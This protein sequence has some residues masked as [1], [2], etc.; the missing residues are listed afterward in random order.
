MKQAG[1]SFLLNLLWKI[2]SYLNQNSLSA[3]T[4]Y[5]DLEAGAGSISSQVV[6]LMVNRK[7]CDWESKDQSEFVHLL[8][9]LLGFCCLC[10]S[11]WIWFAAWAR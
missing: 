10:L 5:G 9:C 11:S 4:L 1:N 2:V 7:S 8:F 6:V 3:N